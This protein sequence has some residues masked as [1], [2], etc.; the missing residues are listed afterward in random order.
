MKPVAMICQND[1]SGSRSTFG[2]RGR[3]S[4]WP[5]SAS[6]FV[7]VWQTPF[8]TNPDDFHVGFQATL[9]KLL[10]Q[11]VI[12]DFEI[13]KPRCRRSGRSLLHRGKGVM[14]R[15]ADCVLGRIEHQR[16][17]AQGTAGSP[18]SSVSICLL[19]VDK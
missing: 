7:L 18:L 12:C 19:S 3:S 16:T 17:R 15:V 9:I 5:N 1:I 14:Q 4:G 13:Q 10:A 8:M 2:R 6:P 11:D